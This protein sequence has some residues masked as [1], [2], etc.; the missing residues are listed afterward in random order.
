MNPIS[1]F[2]VRLGVTLL[3][4]VFEHKLFFFCSI[5][6]TWYSSSST[7]P[8]HI[9]LWVVI[10]HL[11]T[12]GGSCGLPG[13][14][15]EPHCA[16]THIQT[17]QM[18]LERKWKC[19]KVTSL[20]A[21]LLNRHFDPSQDGYCFGKLVTWNFRK[22]IFENSK[23]KF[24]NRNLDQRILVIL[25]LNVILTVWNFEFQ[26]SGYTTVRVVPY[27]TTYT[28]PRVR[29]CFGVLNILINPQLASYV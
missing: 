8:S 3:F 13:T 14:D 2:A 22:T 29:R 27:A 16:H 9:A 24:S 7:L 10:L 28:K 18:R 17:T 25:N 12:T 11:H 26:K 1:G 15:L 20:S 6:W 21:S 5:E 23:F 19:M 4:T